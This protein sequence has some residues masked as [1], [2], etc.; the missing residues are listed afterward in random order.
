MGGGKKRRK[1]PGGRG[2]GGGKK[3][4]K[5]GLRAQQK[6]LRRHDVASR[7]KRKK[8]EQRT[9]IQKQRKRKKQI[10]NARSPYIFPLARTLLLGEGNFSFARA[11]VRKYR[12]ILKR[13]REDEGEENERGDDSVSQKPALCLLATCYDSEDELQRKYGATAPSIVSQV[14]FIDILRV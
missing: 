14:C 13:A 11:L 9:R 6:S 10:L 12:A 4:K 5:G 1:G 7:A 8:D 3:R 2:G